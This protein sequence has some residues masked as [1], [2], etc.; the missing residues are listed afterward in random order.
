MPDTSPRA[1]IERYRT[2]RQALIDALLYGGTPT[3]CLAA[4][5]WLGSA[6]GE[7]HRR[8]E[9]GKGRFD[10]KRHRRRLRPRVRQEDLA[11]AIGVS[12][13]AVGRWEREKR[14]PQRWAQRALAPLLG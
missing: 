8:R 12:R 1:V 4:I 10:L 2:G 5:A 13:T 3:E 6:A 7:A 9:A 11:R 14:V